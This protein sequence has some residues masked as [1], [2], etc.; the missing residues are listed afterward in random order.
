MQVLLHHNVPRFI[1][2]IQNRGGVTNS[3][4]QWLQC[5]IDTPEY[6][7]G[8]L[9]RAD[10]YLLYPKNQETF[11]KALFVLTLA[12]AIMSFVP[13]GIHFFGLHFCSEIENFVAMERNEAET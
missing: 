10:E 3:E 4:I 8:L 11:D 6:P 13:G 7:E 2:H 5:D 12:I 1:A 9:A